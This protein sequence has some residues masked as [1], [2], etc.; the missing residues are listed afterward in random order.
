MLR[1]VSFA[2]N[3]KDLE[4]RVF[5][6][7][8]SFA[9]LRFFSYLA[10]GAILLSLG[11]A[12]Q[13]HS[14][15]LFSSQSPSIYQSVY[16]DNMVAFVSVETWF[17]SALWPR[18]LIGSLVLFLSLKR[19]KTFRGAIILVS[20]AAFLVHMSI[21]LYTYFFET[22]NKIS[23]FECLASN[24][25]GGALLSFIYVSISQVSQSLKV[26]A[27]EHPKTARFI[28]G[29]APASIA[30]LALLIQ[31][32][33]LAL[34]FNPSPAYVE[35]RVGPEAT[36]SLLYDDAIKKQLEKEAL[37]KCQCEKSDEDNKNFNFLSGNFVGSFSITGQG[38]EPSIVWHPAPNVTADVIVQAYDG[39][40][41]LASEKFP[42]P[43]KSSLY[44]KN[45]SAFEVKLPTSMLYVKSLAN[46]GGL[47]IQDLKF[48]PIWLS[49]EGD[50]YSLTRFVSE[51]HPVEYKVNGGG[52]SLEITIPLLEVAQ[53]PTAKRADKELILIQD[54]RKI[55]L[56]LQPSAIGLKMTGCSA[57]PFKSQVNDQSM[58]ST[59]N[60]VSFRLII[61]PN[62]PPSDV[63]YDKRSYAS[64]NDLTGWY[65]VSKLAGGA[66]KDLAIPGLVQGLSVFRGLQFLSLN[67]RPVEK[68]DN[69]TF[70]FYKSSL[71]AHMSNDS[72]LIMKGESNLVW[73]DG[74]RLSPTR[75]EN[76]DIAT[77][78]ILLGLAGFLMLGLS[79]IFR[80]LW[81]A[82]SVLAP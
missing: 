15:A 62:S 52:L 44:L 36:I 72:S 17:V 19:S 23:L 38:S 58:I 41:G 34:F 53:G 3:F 14:V 21:D 66:T 59:N 30:S 1:K 9:M 8:M 80:S 75:W 2:I 24:A 13:Q 12:F 51:K 76:M 20:L 57:I 4:V 43:S 55:N 37:D 50:T 64:F 63:V 56:K 61:N 35:A 45:V 22:P 78:G 68:I 27:T 18:Y 28:S 70:T 32:Y 25:L 26:T 6:F 10:C 82:N 79:A 69:R 40:F 29:I 42:K 71:K 77:Q 67:G 47:K 74:R 60:V 31:Y 5:S 16:S 48:A 11:P 39:C 7:L 49:K 33:V 54:G 73:V 81:K 46:H 65:S